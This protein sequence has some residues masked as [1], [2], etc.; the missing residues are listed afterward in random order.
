[1]QALEF[2]LAQLREIERTYP[3]FPA[4]EKEEL[5]KL[6]ERKW[7]LIKESRRSMPRIKHEKR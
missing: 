7:E 6:K 3:F 4:R 1:M 5:R 2:R